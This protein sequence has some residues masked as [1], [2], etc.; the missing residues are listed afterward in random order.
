MS[1]LETIIS[2]ATWPAERINEIQPEFQPNCP[3]CGANSED[4]MHCYWLCPCNDDI[5]D[6]RVKDTQSLCTAAKL[7]VADEPCLWL[8]GIMPDNKIQIPPEELP[9]QDTTLTKI[10]NFD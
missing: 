2:G 10:S 7:R 4:E 1:L 6:S 9:I 8:R 3:R 5:D